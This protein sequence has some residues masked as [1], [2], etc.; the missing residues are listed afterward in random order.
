MN[1]YLIELLGKWVCFLLVSL[2]S[3]LG[4]SPTEKYEIQDNNDKNVSV[5]TEIIPYETNVTYNSSIP[6]NITRTVTEGSN[7]LKFMS[8]DGTEVILQEVV[9]EEIEVGTGAYGVY[10]GIMTGYG[11]D[12]ATCDGLGY[13]A[14]STKDKKSYN[15][16]T[17]GIYY[18]DEEYGEV[19][20]LAA[21]LAEFPC[22]TI[23]EV[24]SSNLGK[25]MGIVM[26][27]GYDM[28]RF[29]SMGIYHFDVAYD[30]EEDYMVP[31]TTN[32]TG[33]VVYSVQRWGW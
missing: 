4:F 23:V 10:K 30:T 2:S 24:D 25:F 22:G 5:L 13:V 12:C 6:S 17:D 27:T 31:Y 18:N 19:R 7:G 32:M 15:I 11:P 1:F 28:R 16:I 14:C 29:Y 26:D 8:N 33:E 21:A 20:V 9:N 3:F